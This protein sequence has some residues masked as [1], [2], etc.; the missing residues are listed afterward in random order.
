M[1]AQS[2]HLYWP[3]S[4]RREPCRSTCPAADKVRTGDQPKSCESAWSR[5]AADAARPRRRGDR[6]KRR[7]FITLLS[8]AVACPLSA[9]AQQTALPVIGFLSSGSLGPIVEFVAAFKRC[10]GQACYVEG[11]NV[12][13]EYHFAESRYQ[14]LPA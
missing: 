9:R 3:S 2:G 11:Q 6:M 8:G 1:G 5:S 14:R 4:K 12:A 7:E 10:L 13:I